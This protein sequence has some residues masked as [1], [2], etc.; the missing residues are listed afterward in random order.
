MKRSEFLKRFGIGAVVIVTTPAV[1]ASMLAKEKFKSRKE[2]TP[3]EYHINNAKKAYRF[4]PRGITPQD[5]INIYRRTG[6]FMY[7]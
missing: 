2:M 1:L 4:I 6:K 7:L 3:Q 5:C